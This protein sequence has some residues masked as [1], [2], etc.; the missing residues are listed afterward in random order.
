MLPR[1]GYCWRDQARRMLW[2]GW[3]LWQLRR[4]V[5]Q[6]S[7]QMVTISAASLTRWASGF[8]SSAP[9][10]RV[11]WRLPAGLVGAPVRGV[12]RERGSAAGAQA[13]QG[14]RQDPLPGVGVLAGGQRGVVSAG[15]L[16]QQRDVQRGD[17]RPQHARL[18]RPRDQR[19][20]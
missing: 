13:L 10:D 2:M 18:V 14:D 11:G 15:L 19:F 20:G 17:V 6:S 7:P 3:S 8:R 1:L 9:D 5:L 4:L 16:D 12:A